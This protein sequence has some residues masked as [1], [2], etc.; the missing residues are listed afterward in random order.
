M[1]ENNALAYETDFKSCVTCIMRRGT[2]CL[3]SDLKTSFCCNYGSL[4]NPF[5][6]LCMD[7][8]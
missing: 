5:Q 1:I 6:I 4:N 7:E 8:Y 2:H 3:A